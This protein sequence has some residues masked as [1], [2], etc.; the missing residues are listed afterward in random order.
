VV[1]LVPVDGLRD[2]L[3]DVGALFVID[4]FARLPDIRVR[5]SE[6]GVLRLFVDDLPNGYESQLGDDGVRLSGGQRQRVAL[7]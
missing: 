2:T 3:A 1:R 7:A 5:V 6:V 4:E